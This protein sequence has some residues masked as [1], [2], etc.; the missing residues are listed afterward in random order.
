[1]T[2]GTKLVCF[3]CQQQEVGVA[4]S[5][6]QPTLSGISTVV[7]KQRHVISHDSELLRTNGF[8]TAKIQVKRAY[9]NR[10]SD[11]TVARK[12][13]IEGLYVSAWRR[14]IEKLTKIPLIYSV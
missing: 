8:R 7:G 3:L 1:V 12:S 4:I 2:F 5:V 11:R 10:R 9:L 14:G 13:S 6:P